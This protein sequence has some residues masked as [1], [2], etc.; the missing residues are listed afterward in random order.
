MLAHLDRNRLV[1]VNTKQKDLFE[2]I[3]AVANSEASTR[4]VRTRAQ[5]GL[6]GRSD[7]EVQALATWLKQRVQKVSRG[8]RQ[9]TYR[10]LRAIL[11]MHGYELELK[12]GNRADVIRVIEKK[13]LFRRDTTIERKRIGTIGYHSDG[14]PVA[15]REIKR[16]RA[17][18]KLT[19]E[20]GCD[21]DGFYATAE[22]Y[23]VFINQH[24]TILRRLAHA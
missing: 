24:R 14:M 19:E 3:L 16:I 23:D 9:I 4:L 22:T 20:D 7:A 1:L 8:E 6:R 18:T 21:S 12:T 17:L 5:H 13:G 11:Q 2:M 10:Q 15:M